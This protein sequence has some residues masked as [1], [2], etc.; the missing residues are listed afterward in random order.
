M[1]VIYFVQHAEKEPGPGDPEL[2]ERGRGQ[3]HADDATPVAAVTHGGVTV[4]L[5]RT[6]IGDAA[7]PPG[8]IDGG[9]P[10]C[11]LTVLDGV[12]VIDV[13]ATGHLPQ[14][15]ADCPDAT[16]HCGVTPEPP[17]RPR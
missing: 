5:L 16:V 9:V 13:A 3:A 1:A 15:G 6:L 8:L 10:A 11:A 2:T 7:L 12:A 14:L 17:R 4:E